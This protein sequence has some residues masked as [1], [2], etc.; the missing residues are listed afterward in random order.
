MSN[1]P[2]KDRIFFC[3]FK[4]NFSPLQT[5]V[6]IKVQNRLNSSGV[7]DQTQESLAHDIQFKLIFSGYWL[8]TA[9][10]TRT[11]DCGPEPEPQT[12]RL[13]PMILQILPDLD[14]GYQAEWRLTWRDV[15]RVMVTSVTLVTC[16]TTHHTS[17]YQD[18]SEFHWERMGKRG[19]SA[20]K[21]HIHTTHT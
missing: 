7:Q 10:L 15:W 13:A 12:R 16:Y 21:L 9:G 6:E 11:P 4:N 3:F 14:S 20:L 1:N 5:L 2:V 18:Q 19:L 8:E 17:L